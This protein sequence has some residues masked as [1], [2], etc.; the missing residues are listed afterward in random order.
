MGWFKDLMGEEPI[1]LKKEG[2]TPDPWVKEV[3]WEHTKLSFK[4]M[5]GGW[6]AACFV[7]LVTI[8]V[9]Y[10]LIEGVILPLW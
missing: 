3:K 4:L 5:L 9:V 7:I 1:S 6:V 2:W 8:E 10:S